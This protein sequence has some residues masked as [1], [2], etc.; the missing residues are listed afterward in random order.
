MPDTDYYQILGVGRDADLSA[1]KKAYRQLAVRYHPDKNPGDPAAGEQFKQAAE[2][3]AALS[4]PE[5]RRRY[6]TYGKAGIGG[7]GGFQ[8]FDQEILADFGDLLGA[9][10][11]D[12]HECR[13]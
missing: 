11:L 3:Y 6:D 2:A 5:K 13:S 1:I 10:T 4:G 12:G 9:P 7:Q 8:G